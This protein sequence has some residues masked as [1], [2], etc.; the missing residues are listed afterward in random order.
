MNEMHCSLLHQRL[1]C[2]LWHAVVQREELAQDDAKLGRD[3]PRKLAAVLQWLRAWRW[4]LQ[5][6]DQ[7]LPLPAP[8][9]MES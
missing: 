6:L 8:H 9:A 3:A 7:L 2:S 1:D 4:V 5:A